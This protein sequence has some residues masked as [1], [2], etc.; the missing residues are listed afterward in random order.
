MKMWMDV[1]NIR[2]KKGEEI[3][4]VSIFSMNRKLSSIDFGN[5]EAEDFFKS[6]FFL[7][8]CSYTS[9]FYTVKF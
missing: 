6:G 2:G 3:S 8:I 7:L 4:T 9:L 1:H 5:L